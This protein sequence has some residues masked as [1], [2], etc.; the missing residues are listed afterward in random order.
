MR[1]G[2]RPTG[3]RCSV[4]F[5][6]PALSVSQSVSQYPQLPTVTPLTA[7]H[8][9]NSAQRLHCS[10]PLLHTAYSPLA[11]T[12]PFSLPSAASYLQPNCTRRTSGHSLGTFIALSLRSCCNDCVAYHSTHFLRFSPLCDVLNCAKIK[13]R[14]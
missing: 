14:T 1:P 9:Q 11:I 2:G 13:S 10:F 3:S 5:L 6:S 4:P 12:L 7:R 8:T